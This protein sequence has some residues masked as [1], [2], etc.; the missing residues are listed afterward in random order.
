MQKKEVVVIALGRRA[1]GNTLPDQKAA[2]REAAKAVADIVESG[3]EVV[4]THSNSA[5]IGMIHTAMNEF[6]INH[7]NFTPVP[8]SVCT[9]MA[10]GY[11]G[12][13]LQNAI[14]AEL[15]TRQIQKP[16][17]TVMTQVVVDPYDE[18]FYEPTKIIGRTLTKDEA[19]KEEAKGNFVVKT[20]SGYRRIVAAPTPREIVELPTVKAL[21]AAGQVVI[22]CGGGGIPVFEQGVDL[23]GASAVIEKDTVS[24]LLAMDLEADVLMI[25]T[26]VDNVTLNFRKD[27]EKVINTI[28]VR[29]ALRYCR[30]SKFESG[31]VLPKMQAAINFVEM[32]E[33][34]RA[35]ITSI[36]RAKAALN[37]KAGTIITYGN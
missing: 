12:Y 32:K 25:L 35:I 4:V 24:A 8:M 2:V 10:Q 15:M 22:C 5:Q 29:E 36:P 20:K 1:L 6:S 14:R 33:G 31:S 7:E 27:N 23:Q 13:D 19:E 18:A 21:V 30:D 28:T 37:G 26:S 17:A 3:R 9:A 16:V 11:I 34:R